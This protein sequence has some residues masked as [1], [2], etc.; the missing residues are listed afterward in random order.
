MYI[1]RTFQ[2]KNDNSNN[3]NSQISDMD[4]ARKEGPKVLLG[5]PGAGKTST[6]EAIAN[7]LNG[8]MVS[9][10]NI[11]SGLYQDGPDCGDQILVIDGLDEV[12]A[13]NVPE[14]F[15]KIITAIKNLNYTNWMISCRSYE[16]QSKL[17]DENIKTAFGRPVNI[18]YIGDLSD[19]EIISFL[20]NFGF[21]GG[22]DQFLNRA[23]ENE[24]A[25]LIRNPQT[26]E[27][28]SKAIQADGWPDTK[29]D[30]FLSACKVMASED[31]TI[32]QSYDQNRPEP[33]KIICIAGW[34]C[35]QLLMSG[36]R[37][38][39]MGGISRSSFFRPTELEGIQYSQKDI[40]AAC[41]TKLFKTAEENFVEPAHRTI[42]EFLAGKWLANEFSANPHRLSPSRVMNF[43]TFG[44][45]E[46]P[47]ALRGLHAWLTSFDYSYRLEN[48]KKD[49]YGCFRYGDLSD[50][51]DSEIIS[52]LDALFEL[53][54][55]NFLFESEDRYARFGRSIGRPSI[56]EKFVNIITN[57]AA[58]L[59]LK[60]IL[61][62]AIQGTELAEI[63]TDDLKAVILNEAAEIT[64]RTTAADT[65]ASSSKVVD[66]KG[67][68]DGLL[69][70]GTVNS[71][72]V[73]IDNILSNNIHFF[74]GY[75]I[76]E[77]IKAYERGVAATSPNDITIDVGY[78][79]A[80]KC[81]DQQIAEIAKS[82]AADIP[83]KYD[84]GR[85]GDYKAL[86]EWLLEFTLHWT[87]CAIKPTVDDLWPLIVK[88]SGDF[89][90]KFGSRTSE[91]SFFIDNEDIRREIQERAFDRSNKYYTFTWLGKIQKDLYVSE[92]D[93]I[94][95]MKNLTA[96]D[97]K[98]SDW[99]K[100]WDFLVRWSRARDV[101]YENALQLAKQQAEQFSE[102]QPF[103]ENFLNPPISDVEQENQRQRHEWN[104][105]RLANAKERHAD[106]SNVRKK[107]E[108]G[109]HLGALGHAADA[110]LGRIPDLGEIA[111]SRGK[112]IELVGSENIKSV[113]SG[114]EAVTKKDNLPS[115]R[116]CAQL[117]LESKEF[118]TEKISL[119]HCIEV[120]K[121]G[122][123]LKSLPRAAQICALAACRW[124][125]HFPGNAS[126]KIQT[127]LEEILFE[128]AGIK[129]SF[130]KDT[131]EPS[132][133]KKEEHVSSLYRITTEDL[134][135]DIFP[136]LAIEWLTKFEN[137]SANVVQSL[138][139]A[140]VRFD[141]KGE[142]INL[143]E[144]RFENKFFPTDEHRCAWHAAAFALDF[145]RFFKEVDA[146][147]DE[148]KEH[149][150]S[151][152]DIVSKNKYNEDQIFFLIN[153]FASRWPV[154][155]SPS[156]VW[157]GINN[158]WDATERISDLIRALGEMKTN[159]A[160]AHF[161]T[162]KQSENVGDY[163]DYIN[164]VFSQ[165]KRTLAEDQHSEVTL[166]DVRAVLSSGQATNVSDLQ[167]IFLEEI[168][169]Y[170][171]RIKNGQTDTYLTFWN[172]SRPHH[173]NYCRDRILDGMSE[174]MAKYGVRIHK[175]GAVA[176]NC[177]VDLLLT[178][179]DFDLP[180]EIKGQWH[181]DI[182]T[183]AYDQLEK[184][185]QD[186]RT[187]GT[188]VYLVIWHGHVDKKNIKKPPK[189]AKPNSADK[190]LSALQQNY[191][192]TISP[193]TKIFVLDVS[194][195]A[196]SKKPKKSKGAN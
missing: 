98:P 7:K 11:A 58:S 132:L 120:Y 8:K 153:K 100:R 180:V 167:T 162:L 123:S 39:S 133:E 146:F 24:A 96:I 163:Q 30:L 116:E 119:V 57:N 55:T 161:E 102:L 181:P 85:E 17:F 190:V 51:Q 47:S 43:F 5:A 14:S 94:Y 79:L 141:D 53:S 186:Y 183:A 13:S 149:F 158:D 118:Q 108:Q 74:T 148:K 22:V 195:P 128:D 150:W 20:E 82:I 168:K 192:S 23:A 64:E 165:A 54:K 187:D 71:L 185:S 111:T 29:K 182:W 93:V 33:N 110:A 139:K 140:A 160:I 91:H 112:I 70:S 42:A 191:L 170:Q 127:I 184:Y 138:L 80:R 67:V 44:I 179:K 38:V 188:G 97:D 88:L 113:I 156:G 131:I 87:T 50:F 68:A 159:K 115:A 95:H 32:H 101:V 12:L 124:G 26:L 69:S 134:F 99:L 151:F 103:F 177:R 65:L 130:V 196:R 121:S 129:K 106:F 77:H 36:G 62:R 4:F 60:Y 154:V 40:A 172:E 114:F 84:L 109:E 157:V 89:S 90:S 19:E 86:E 21:D 194:K 56:K 2:I 166:D 171:K 41:R 105:K 173:E 46:I 145:D 178:C 59:G 147:S 49:P 107:M 135:S 92:P 48:I 31:N 126:E 142:L 6:A 164:H 174:Q 28:L 137:A 73:S 125:L 155:K 34:I 10:H 83:E 117:H 35:A 16:W 152:E 63:I 81:S 27:M 61:L 193:K 25:D 45:G 3:E 78:G 136:N 18:A 15:T 104:Q 52:F 9:A 37:G 76:S 176:N 122:K 189:G 169:K 1:K 144:T 66:W 75:D 175:E 143:V 72:R